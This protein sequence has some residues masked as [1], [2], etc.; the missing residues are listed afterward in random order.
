MEN[1][2]YMFQTSSAI[3]R[4]IV[5]KIYD[6]RTGDAFCDS[7]IPISSFIVYKHIIYY[8]CPNQIYILMVI[9]RKV[10]LISN[11]IHLTW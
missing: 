7:V 3:Q 4:N 10:V 6:R 1:Q 2:N 5:F 8:S 9:R 11:D